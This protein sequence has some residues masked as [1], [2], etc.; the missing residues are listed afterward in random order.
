MMWLAALLPAIV[1]LMIC[2]RVWNS[3]Q[4]WRDARMWR[5]LCKAMKDA[6][7]DDYS[8]CD[9]ETQRDMEKLGRQWEHLRNC[10]ER[11]KEKR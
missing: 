3:I 1:L 10:A 7:D 11:E 9:A 5:N 4:D 6:L 2:A 8:D